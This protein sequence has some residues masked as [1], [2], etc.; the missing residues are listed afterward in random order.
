VPARSDVVALIGVAGSV[1]VADQFSKV[2]LL[3]FIGPGSGRHS[4]EVVRPWLEL[5]YAE[6]RGAAFGLFPDL[7]SLVT[8]AALAIVL[9]L[10]RQFAR[11]HRPP[12]W[13][14][15]ATGAIAG[16]ALGNVIDRL[17]LGY[18]IDFIAVGPWP[19]FNIAD[20]AITLGALLLCWGWLRL[21]VTSDANPV[22]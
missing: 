12:W 17:R 3:G 14:A 4:L 2:L 19:N 6:N 20:S 11:E 21:N 22:G 16:G 1:L 8:V 7:G 15:V 18:V 10:L 9:G 5:E 13:Q